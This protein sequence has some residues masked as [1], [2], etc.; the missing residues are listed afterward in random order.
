M[1]NK[2]VSY[3]DAFTRSRE[4]IRQA[5]PLAEELGVK[6]ALEN[7][8][9]NFLLSPLEAAR[10]VDDFNSPMVG[11]HF[12]CGNVWNYGWPDQWI[13]ILGKR[14]VKIHIKEF[15]RKKADSEGKWKGFE[16]KLLEG[17][18]EW[19]AIMKAL[20]DV[21]YTGWIIAE[22]GGA[23]SPEGLKDISVRMDKILG[24]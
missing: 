5:V 8:W 7:V 16:V 23:G 10:F 12:D 22:Q 6:I 20:D 14:I 1:V 24:L 9:N 13:R 18:M 21:G 11:W 4:M 19:P 2:E 3:A 15:S 17:D